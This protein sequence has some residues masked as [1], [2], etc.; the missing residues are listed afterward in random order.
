MNSCTYTPPKF[1]CVNCD[2]PIPWDR[3]VKLFCSDLCKNESDYVRY[4]RRCIQDGRIKQPDIQEA[5]HIKFVF[6]VSGGYPRDERVISL[7]IRERVIAL[8]KGRCAICGRPGSDIDHVL[9]S[10]NDI[11]N[12]QL[13]CRECHNKKT[14]AGFIKIPP[15]DPRYTVV[16]QKRV[17]LETRIYALTPKRPCDNQLDWPTISKRIRNER[18]LIF[19]ESL[20]PIVN[21]LVEKDLSLRRIAEVLNANSVRTY[22]GHGWW[23]RHM[24]TGILHLMKKRAK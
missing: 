17:E 18:K 7:E 21:D 4:Y 10:D 6:L 20:V 19:F 15:D 16:V 22:S 12:L 8:Y 2:R 9:G 14:V 5:L 3:R 24:M 13:L 23:D 11:S 1:P